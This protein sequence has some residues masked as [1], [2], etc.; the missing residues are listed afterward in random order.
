M[1]GPYLKQAYQRD[2]C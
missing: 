2:N 1:I